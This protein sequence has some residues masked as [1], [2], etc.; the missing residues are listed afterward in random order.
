MGSGLCDPKPPPTK[1]LLCPP[2]VGVTWT[3]QRQAGGSQHSRKPRKHLRGLMPRLREA[4]P[5]SP[6]KPSTKEATHSTAGSE[7]SRRFPG[8]MRAVQREREAGT[9]ERHQDEE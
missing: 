7:G 1:P 6:S 5:L 3:S 8:E 9:G 2:G 4:R